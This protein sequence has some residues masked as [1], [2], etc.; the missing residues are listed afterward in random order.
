MNCN[1][2]SFLITYYAWY[3]NWLNWI[4]SCIWNLYW[5]LKINLFIPTN[6]IEYRLIHCFYYYVYLVLVAKKFYYKTAIG[7]AIITPMDKLRRNW[8]QW[9]I[10]IWADNR[11]QPRVPVL[12]AG[13]KTIEKRIKPKGACRCIDFADVM[14]GRKLLT[15]SPQSSEQR[16]RRT[17]GE[18]EERKKERTKGLVWAQA[19]THP[20]WRLSASAAIRSRTARSEKSWSMIG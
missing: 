17:K 12:N 1:T 16:A 19:H 9:A 10:G 6:F 13:T 18:M 11:R 7:K 4:L 2:V 3:T 15:L 5:E 8:E 14:M 20:F